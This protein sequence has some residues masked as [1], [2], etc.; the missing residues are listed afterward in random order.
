[1]VWVWEND[2]CTSI[3]G[4]LC[5][6]L[7]HRFTQFRICFAFIPFDF[8]PIIQNHI[9]GTKESYNAT[10]TTTNDMGKKSH[11]C[12]R[13][14]NITKERHKTS[15]G[16]LNGAMGYITMLPKAKVMQLDRPM[17]SLKSHHTISDNPCTHYHVIIGA[18]ESAMGLIT[19]LYLFKE[20]LRE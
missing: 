12:T 13:S 7:C 9:P 20:A 8:I 4:I 19:L 2:K 5:K 14:Y 11:R 17:N 6:G 10:A 15:D 18:L 3:Y 16:I 1:M